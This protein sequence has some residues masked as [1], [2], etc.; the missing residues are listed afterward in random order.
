M[1]L[2]IDIGNT[3]TVLG[4]FDG[5]TLTEHWRIA[6]RIDY[7]ADELGVILAGLLA[8]AHV[9]MEK[10]DSVVVSSVV[11]SLNQ[12][13]AS[14]CA[15][16][17]GI[18]PL[19]IGPGVRTGMQIRYDNPREVGAD[20]IVNSVAAFTR[21][22]GPAVVID[23]G[24]AT[25][26]D[27]IGANGDYLGGVIAPGIRISMDALFS[28]AAKL[29][30]FE[31]AVPAGLEGVIGKNTVESMQAGFV[32]GFAGQIEGIVRRM[33]EELGGECRVIATGG[34]AAL[35]ATHAKVI[36]TV[37]ETLTLDGLRLLHEL[38]APR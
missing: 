12:A 37:D 6:T 33:R 3:N 14:M 10:L 2:A 31:L 29:P 35:I 30:R 11:P 24:T 7:T 28:R 4:T 5:E 38:N 17:L 13:I 19:V 20:R 8:G 21:Y 25:T 26:F 32:F 36:E 34:L 22:G 16:S 15:R 18:E 1:L 9:P 23:F 27:A